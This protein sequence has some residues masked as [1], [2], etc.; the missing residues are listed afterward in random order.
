LAVLIVCFA[1]VIG[2]LSLGNGGLLARVARTQP[3]PAIGLISYGLY[4]YHFPI[5]HLVHGYPR[6]RVGWLSVAVATALTFAVAIASYLIVE[7]RALRLKH[8]RSARAAELGK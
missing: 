6:S 5:N 7:R 8:R 3:L 2:H 1:I 4:L